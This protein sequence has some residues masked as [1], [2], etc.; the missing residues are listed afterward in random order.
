M[1][2]GLRLEG[3]KKQQMMNLL[4]PP[5][6]CHCGQCC[7]YF[8]NLSKFF[9]SALMLAFREGPRSTFT[10]TLR[11]EKGGRGEEGERE[12]VLVFASCMTVSYF[13]C[14]FV[15]AEAILLFLLP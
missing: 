15:S 10:T 1:K 11:R 2:Q 5:L 9:S 6:S 13:S 8:P 14:F 7:R 3:E 4:C 12:E